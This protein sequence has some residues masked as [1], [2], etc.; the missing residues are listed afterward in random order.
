MRG[1]AG[2]DASQAGPA[3]Q[4]Q[5]ASGVASVPP[6]GAVPI[7][8]ALFIA[9]RRSQTPRNFTALRVPSRYLAGRDDLRLALDR[10]VH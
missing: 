3:L 7:L 6:P 2:L 8:V 4:A 5:A 9:G 1:K 10:E